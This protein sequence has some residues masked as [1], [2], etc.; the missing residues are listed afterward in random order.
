MREVNERVRE[1]FP[2]SI[3]AGADHEVLEILCECGRDD[4]IETLELT[5]AEY[6]RVRSSPATFAVLPGHEVGEE[7]QTVE[8]NERFLVVYRTGTVD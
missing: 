2:G 3:S 7:E 4:C 8:A 1:T 6:E 5:V